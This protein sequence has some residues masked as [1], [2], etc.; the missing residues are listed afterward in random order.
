MINAVDDLCVDAFCVTNFD[1]SEKLAFEK[2]FIIFPGKH[3]SQLFFL[4]YKKRT[5]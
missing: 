2:T 3:G 1:F 5:S 4:G